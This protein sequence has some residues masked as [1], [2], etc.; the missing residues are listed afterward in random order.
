MKKINIS[1][2]DTLFVNGN[3]PIEMLL[4]YEHKID[5]GTIKKSLKRISSSFWPLFGQYSDGII[6]S[7]KYSEGK[8]LS[9]SIYTEDFDA[10]TD[11]MEIWK[12][13][14][15]VSPK[16][17]ERLFFLSILQFNNGTV[18]IPK[19]NHLVGDGYSYFYFLSVLAALSVQS[20]IPFKKLAISLLASPQLDRTVIRA[21]QFN[22]TRIEEPLDHQNCSIEIEQVKK[23]DVKQEIKK[24]KT[25]YD[26]SVS[27]NDILSA[28]V[29]KKTFEKQKKVID[30]LFTLSIPMDVRQQVKDLGPKFFG[31]G[32][33]IHH[34]KL[35]VEEL[36][37]IDI[38]ELA[39]KLRK[40]MPSVNR[41]DYVKFLNNLESEIEGASIHALKPYDPERGCLVTNLSRMP[42]QKLNFGS[43]NPALVVP[44]TIG[45]NSAA[46]LAD[47][48]SFILRL[49][50]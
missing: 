21:Y 23:R 3:Y 41:E 43:G 26:T 29:F 30:S 47:R 28:M 14:N 8:F 1:Q 13:Y 18:I 32:L 27:A 17:M 24:I 40:S 33:M 11:Q 50:Y 38:S 19:M 5:T 34:L 2:I 22:K 45:R 6:Q 9:E 42:I 35:S 46:V 44:L 20:N 31:N 25:K 39:V 12:K 16:E 49:V 4:F 7:S 36:E 10:D 48:E 37:E 15:A